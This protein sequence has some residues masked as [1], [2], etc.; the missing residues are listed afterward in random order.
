MMSF[1]S[2]VSERDE[3]SVIRSGCFDTQQDISARIGLSIQQFEFQEVRSAFDTPWTL[4][5]VCLLVLRAWSPTSIA[6][7]RDLDFEG[8]TRC[9]WLEPKDQAVGLIGRRDAL[10]QPSD[11]ETILAGLYGLGVLGRNREIPVA[12]EV[13][14]LTGQV[15]ILLQKLFHVS[16]ITNVRGVHGLDGIAE[17]LLPETPSDGMTSAPFFPSQCPPSLTDP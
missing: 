10:V 3:V 15:R 11:F 2:D 5:R 12:A 9:L 7:I 17:D 1:N 16:V 8:I 6:G 13:Q 4:E 14:K